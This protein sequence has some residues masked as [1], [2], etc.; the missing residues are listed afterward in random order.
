M[1]LLAICDLAVAADHATF[2]LPEVKVGVFPMQVIAP[3]RRLLQPRVLDELCLTGEPLTASEA[4]GAGLVNYVVPA[5]ELDAK[6]AW[7]TARLIDKSPTAQRRGKYALRA[8]ADM[9]F[10]EAL[11][12][13]EGQIATLALT[14]DAREGRRAFAERR[15]PQWTNR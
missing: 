10:L 9:S 2:G 11:A 15:P 8:S 13:L 14:E 12:F 5:A 7:L 1:G 6:I 4:R 3:L